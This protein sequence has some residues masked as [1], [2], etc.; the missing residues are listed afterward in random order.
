MEANFLTQLVDEPTR[1]DKSILDL[2]ITNNSSAILN[3]NVSKTKLSDHDIVSCGLL[4]KGLMST[5]PI[6]PDLADSHPLEGLDFSRADYDAIREDLN[7]V[8]WQNIL[9]TNANTDAMFQAIDEVISTIC[10]KHTPKHKNPG[11]NKPYIPKSRRSLQNVLKHL[12]YKINFCKRFK[13]PNYEKRI[14]AFNKRKADTEVQIRE[15][16]EREAKEKEARAISRFKTNPRT[17][18]S[19]AKEN[20]K[21]PNIIGPLRDKHGNLQADPKTMC[22]ILQQQYVSVFS[23]PQTNH[24]SHPPPAEENSSS[25]ILDDFSFTIED[26]IKTIDCIPTYSAAG[27]DKIPAILLKECK[28]QLAPALLL[29]WRRSLDTGQIPPI[30]LKQVIIPIHK[31]SDKSNPANY[32]PVSLTAHIIKLFERL[33]RSKLVTHLEENSHLSQNQHGFRKG[34]SCLTNLLHHLNNIFTILEQNDNADVLYIDMSKAFDK[35]DHCTLLR[36]LH[37]MNIRGKILQWIESFLNNRF[38]QVVIRGVSSSEAKVTSGVPQGT[39]L[40]PIL[41]LCY[42]NDLEKVIKHSLISIFADDSKIIKSIRSDEDRANFM[43]DLQAIIAWAEANCMELNA[44][45]YQLLQHGRNNDFKT[46]Y[47]LHNNLQIT[48]SSAVRDLGVH[49][50][51]DLSVKYHV[52]TMTDNAS[53]MAGWTLRTIRSRDQNVMLMLLK[54]Y[55]IP[56]LEYSSPAWSP[57]LIRD[58]QKIEAVQRSFTA[59]ISEVQD[60]DYWQRL[61]A[62]KLYSLQR[63]RERFCIIHAW[64]IKHGLAPNDV[65]LEFY[66]NPR[67]GNQCRRKPLTSRIASIRSL[68]SNFFS[69]SA[70]RLY[71]VIPGYIKSKPNLDTFKRALDTLLQKLPDCPPTPGYVA[72]NNNSLPEL[73]PHLCEAAKKITLETRLHGFSGSDLAQEEM[74]CYSN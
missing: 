25:P 60:L 39:V 65:A 26:I 59:K 51:E 16:I 30:F 27:P 43:A 50:S 61:Q 12:N 44:D 15:E 21:T 52:H 40:G 64:K 45:K 62:L 5:P 41:F 54:T 19:F 58:I 35:V 56:R 8:D 17:F 68:R 74:V 6:V 7:Q 66:D 47:I 9:P 73:V 18:Y 20:S 2:I 24:P 72:P 48:K 71:N 38:Q 42:I 13:P 31:K 4:Y 23:A 67:L 70:P 14:N 36:K 33:L 69:H 11:N 10:P 32:R 22:E 53:R 37:N 28:S 55:I 34:R 29:L 57:H 49:V 46:P 1:E 3:T 63:R